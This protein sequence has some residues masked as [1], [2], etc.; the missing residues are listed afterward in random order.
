MSDKNFTL[1]DEN[2]EKE[3]IEDKKPGKVKFLVVPAAI[4]AATFFIIVICII[5]NILIARYIGD[6]TQ[7][8]KD[9]RTKYIISTIIMFFCFFFVIGMGIGIIV[10]Y[11]RFD[12]NMNL[13]EDDAVLK[14]D[15]GKSKTLLSMIIGISILTFLLLSVSTVLNLWAMYTIP[16]S[17]TYD[18]DLESPI[19]NAYILSW[20]TIIVLVI[21][22]FFIIC[23]VV[24]EIS[25]RT[26]AKKADENAEE[27][28][29]MDELSDDS[30][31]NVD[32]NIE[33]GNS[34]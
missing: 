28:I 26:S 22:L 7:A 9:V 25:N 11:K 23:M 32:S 29:N 27:I 21:G 4:L 13:S 6:S 16:L 20:I 12:K 30:D 14:T 1:G 34:E 17:T 33:S 19:H 24:L 15:M 18:A 3:I 10:F 5:L 2:E 8:L 31:D